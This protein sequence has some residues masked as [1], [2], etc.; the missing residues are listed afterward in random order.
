PYTFLVNPKSIYAF[1][2]QVWDPATIVEQKGIGIKNFWT[3]D[4]AAPKGAQKDMVLNAQDPVQAINPLYISG[5][6]DSWIT[7]LIWDRLVRIGPDGLPRPWA[8][9]A[10]KWLTP[11]TIDVTLRPGM[12]WHDGTPVTADDVIFSFTAPKGGKVPMY[13][14]FV[15]NIADIKK[16]NPTTDRKS[17]RLNSSHV[18]IS[19]AVFCLKKKKRY[20][21][22]ATTA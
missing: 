18:K 12:R 10:Y 3:F 22:H 17:T 4:G 21:P 20:G 16:L 19:Y 15:A 1:N 9:G 8:A 2:N 5:K 14:P 7:E 6:V 13:R 11:T